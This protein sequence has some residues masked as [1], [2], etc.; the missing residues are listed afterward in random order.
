[1]HVATN[2]AGILLAIMRPGPLATTPALLLL[3]VLF[4]DKDE[5]VLFIGA[6]CLL[7]LPWVCGISLLLSQHMMRKTLKIHLRKVVVMKK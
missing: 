4:L 7:H 3:V 1:M 2:R 5:Q 6:L